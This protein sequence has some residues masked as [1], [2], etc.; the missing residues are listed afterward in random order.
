[1][2]AA[3]RPQSGLCCLCVV[4]ALL[5]AAAPGIALAGDWPQFLGPNRDGVSSE[6]GLNWDW[7]ASPP[8][9]LW[10]TPLGSGYSSL[11]IVGDRLFTTTK[12]GDRDIV[13]CLGISDGKERWSY[14]AAPTYIDKQK[15]GSGP[16][17]TPVFHDG[18]LYCLFPMGELIC[19]TADGK[20]V[21]EV[22]VFKDTGAANPAGGFYY[23]GVSYSPLVEGD[24]VI[25]NPGGNKENS[26]A[27][28]DRATGKRLWM[29]GNDPAGYGSPIAITVAGKRC[30]VCPTGASLL[31]ID[32]AAG[33]IL[34]RYEFG[35]KFNATGST[36]VWKENVLFVS[37]AYG[38]GSAALELIPASGRWEVRDLWKNRKNL[39]TLF[40][41]SIVED[42]CIYGAHGD[43]S[44]FQIRCIDL[45]TGGVKWSE[46]VSERYSLLAVD[47][48]LLAW[49]E[50]GNLLALEPNAKNYT[51]AGE[52]PKLLARKSWAMPALADGRL[53]LR[54]ERNVLCLDLRRK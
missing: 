27:A 32:A 54:D 5:P 10:K 50:T 45:R 17:S 13:V 52:M 46:R 8:K 38:A 29:T 34:W 40:A 20:R 41:T 16:R 9:V 18:K 21:W 14:D 3:D 22:N 33:R 48:H 53:Y 23:W 36:P 1:M 49:S 7:K 30:V 12:R 37:A 24:A 25:V 35:N 19:L 11:A 51:L 39:Q 28:Y 47:R 26:I 2:S 31:G 43:L 6:T 42:G 15:Q 44:A 4:L